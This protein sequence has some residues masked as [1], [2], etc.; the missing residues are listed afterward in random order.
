MIPCNFVSTQYRSKDGRP[1]S[2]CSRPGCEA[3]LYNVPE[4]CTA[5]CH[6]PQFHLGD[7]VAIAIE[8][9]SKGKITEKTWPKIVRSWVVMPELLD[10]VDKKK[11]CGCGA[12]RAKLN[13]VRFA[14]PAWVYRLL[15]RFKWITP[16]EISRLDRLVALGQIR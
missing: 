11:D 8:K 1:V 10:E 7:G 12:R 5:T 13:K 4:R 14:F 6:A 9:V 3:V 15:V 2:R 16:P